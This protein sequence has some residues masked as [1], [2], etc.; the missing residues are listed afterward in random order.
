MPQSKKGL[1]KKNTFSFLMIYMKTEDKQMKKEKEEEKEKKLQK[2][3]RYKL[4]FCFP[5]F[6]CNQTD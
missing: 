1:L 3:R 4:L 6:L 2:R 5:R